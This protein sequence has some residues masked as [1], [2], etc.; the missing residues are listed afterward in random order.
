[1]DRLG[2]K[3]I[4]FMLSIGY[5]HRITRGSICAIAEKVVLKLF[6]GQNIANDGKGIIQF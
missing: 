1:M 2:A 5:N 4:P 3:L 6:H